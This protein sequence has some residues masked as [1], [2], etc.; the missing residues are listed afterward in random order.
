MKVADDAVQ[1]HGGYGLTADCAV[2]RYFQEA[3]VLQ[4]GEGTSQLQRALIAEYALGYRQ[5]R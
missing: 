2:G 4:I 5:Q 3:K 1:I